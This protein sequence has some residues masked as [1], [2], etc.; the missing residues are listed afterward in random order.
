MAATIRRTSG[1][2]TSPILTPDRRIRVFVSSTLQELA[3][4]RAAAR[5]AIEGLRFT[6]VL[7]ELGARAHPPQALYRAY[8]DQSD[9]FVGLY[10]QR[11][12][13]VAPGMTISGLEDEYA[14]A[15][16]LPKL[17]YVKRPAD[18]REPRLRD[19]LERI[20]SH[21][22]SYRYF[23]TP[24]EL[25]ELLA[26]DLALLVSERFARRPD[27]GVVHR[28]SLPAP[29]SS[30][31]GRESELEAVVALLRRGDV[32]LLTLTGPGGIG[33]TRLAL[34]A[35]RRIAH[36]LPGGAAYVP[37]ATTSAPGAVVPTIAEAL[38]VTS[39]GDV[40]SLEPLKARLAEQELLLV[41]D[42]MEHVL[43]VAPVVGELLSAVPSL[44]VLATSRT[45][46]DVSGEH[47]FLVPPMSVPDAGE[48][49]VER[50]A[51]SDAVRLFGAR[52]RA[53]GWTTT[54]ADVPIVADIVRRLDG[55]PLAIELAA[56]QARLVP[57]ELVHTRLR[58]RLDLGGGPRDAEERHRTLRSTIAWS[59]DLLDERA[60][61]FFE[62]LSVFVGGFSIEAAAVVVDPGEDVEELLASLFDASLLTSEPAPASGVRFGMLDTIREFAAEG[63]EERGGREEAVT[64][65]LAYFAELADESYDAP[66]DR[67]R[68][69]RL[70]LDEERDNLRAALEEAMRTSPAEGLRLAGDLEHLWS[71]RGLANEGR[72][73]IARALAAAPDAPDAWRARALLAAAWL[74]GEQGDYDETDRKALEA[75]ELYQAIGDARRVG[76][77]LYALGWSAESR[78]DEERAIRCF[79]E[80]LDVLSRVSDEFLK[81]ASA[82][83][84][85]TCVAARGDLAEARRLCAETLEF[86][87]REGLDDER[88]AALL[89]VGSIDERLGNLTAARGSYES[90]AAISRRIANRRVLA[91]ALVHVARLDAAAGRSEDA[92]RSCAEAI[93]LHLELGDR[94]GIAACFE[95]IARLAAARDRA[96]L[97]GQFLGAARALRA[98]A[99][100]PLSRQEQPE[101]AATEAEVRA[102][103]GEAE[104]EREAATG[105]ALP[106]PALAALVETALSEPVRS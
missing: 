69:T 7:F 32:R 41:L 17:V 18:E 96:E 101:V 105:A 90:S 65:H 39:H 5:G 45:R 4:E 15:G 95:G 42:N 25:A 80:S 98:A 92:S 76:E 52:A 82:A 81:A 68:V 77:S 29:A 75:L 84:L 89:Q 30:F 87:E 19:L 78:G 59:Y 58:R 35:A 36:E 16:P 31:V 12:G 8:L 99:G 53:A 74:D 86:F 100:T 10:W 60:R 6:P 22:V 33:K 56:A 44:G 11:Y 2:R 34:E 62:A 26:E 23:E 47:V 106:M 88:A 64:R 54:E 48:Q 104:F 73:T 13:W 46:L 79:E 61:R 91:W 49:A 43:A 103:L 97:A 67:W 93:E 1:A 70:R 14:L 51:G 50:I 9:V 37:L 55:L 20:S 21:E 66:P 28:A 102:R 83:R 71:F 72:A 85:A 57:A 24:D 3:P 27:D 38:G 40:S 94:R 63:L